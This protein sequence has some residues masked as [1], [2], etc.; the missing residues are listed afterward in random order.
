MSDAGAEEIAFTI[1]NVGVG[2]ALEV[3]VFVFHKADDGTAVDETSLT[4]VPVIAP[5]GHHTAK[6]NLRGMANPKLDPWIGGTDVDRDGNPPERIKY[7]YE[8]IRPTYR[9]ATQPPNPS[10]P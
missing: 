7:G 5:G 8:G 1:R 10:V 6:A 4:L 2:P 3:S 9:P